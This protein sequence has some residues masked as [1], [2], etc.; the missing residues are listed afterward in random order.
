MENITSFTDRALAPLL[1]LERN[2]TDVES[3]ISGPYVSR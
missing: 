1:H 2:R 3:C